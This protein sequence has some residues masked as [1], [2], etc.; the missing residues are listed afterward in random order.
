MITYKTP[1]EIL[2]KVK[3]YDHRTEPMYVVPG[4]CSDHWAHRN[5]LAQSVHHQIHES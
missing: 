5:I 2:T 1:D 3:C 4:N